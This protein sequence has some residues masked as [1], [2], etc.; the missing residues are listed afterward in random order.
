MQSTTLTDKE[1]SVPPTE[2]PTSNSGVFI[3]RAKGMPFEEFV[4]HCVEQFKLAG[5]IKEDPDEP[6]PGKS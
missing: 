5:L 3:R 4:N 6:P 1:K 2:L